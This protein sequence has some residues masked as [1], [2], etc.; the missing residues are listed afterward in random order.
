MTA[1]RFL[2]ET[3]TKLL[4]FVSTI[5]L[6]SM[7]PVWADSSACPA[8]SN[9]LSELKRFTSSLRV[10]QDY[11]CLTNY[12]SIS[13]K[14]TAYQLVDVRK[15]PDFQI[16]QAWIIP[17]DELKH[18]TFLAQRPLLLLGDGFSRVSLASDCAL[19][20]RA[21]FTH[22]KMLIG[23]APLWRQASM[24]TKYPST[25]QFVSARNLITE[26]FNGRVSI[27][28]ASEKISENLKKMGI[29]KFATLAGNQFSVVSDL[30]VSTSNGG[31]DPV[32]YVGDSQNQLSINNQQQLPNLYQL[33]GG[34][35]A[36]VTQLNN[37][38]LV[39]ASREAPQG[40]PFCAK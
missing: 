38:V 15:S 26:Y 13:S 31:F 35:D 33:Q 24:K 36:L 40:I 9:Y 2:D 12:P 19:L 17:T 39:E 5:I 1:S 10:E 22:V 20:K 3:L 25:P 37:D 8:S 27:I 29:T 7:R 34:I 30:V 6:S 4:V 16:D 32:V 11:S 18:K 14:I 28:S 23:G 21:G